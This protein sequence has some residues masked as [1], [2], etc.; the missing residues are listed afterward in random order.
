[1]IK[2]GSHAFRREF[3]L[4]GIVRLGGEKSRGEWNQE[5]SYF[6]LTSSDPTIQ[7]AEK[8]VDHYGDK[9]TALDVMFPSDDPTEVFDDAYELW[10]G[11]KKENVKG[12]LLCR[13]D[14]EYAERIIDEE[15]PR[16]RETVV[17]P[18]PDHCAF[19]QEHTSEKV[20]REGG[21]ACG[22]CGRLRFIPYRVSVLEVYEARTGSI[23]AFQGIRNKLLDIQ[24]SPIFQGRISGVPFI[25][26]RVPK[27][28]RFGKTNYPCRIE[29]PTLEEWKSAARF[30][31]DVRQAIMGPLPSGLPK[32]LP[33]PP[34]GAAMPDELVPR[35]NRLQSPATPPPAVTPE[36]IPPTEPEPEAPPREEETPSAE[37][38]KPPATMPPKNEPPQSCAD[39]QSALGP[40]AKRFKVGESGSGDDLVVCLKCH[41]K[42]E[43]N[44]PPAKEPEPAK[45]GGDSTL[46]DDFFGDW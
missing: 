18:T 29:V 36:V 17:C 4:G 23:N 34:S 20:K 7:A 22:A 45:A 15:K 33:Q 6:R 16:E 3:D 2:Q 44:T 41:R 31:C 8:L 14:G 5:L 32:A 30:L 27:R 40:R 19:A 37:T 9:P 38:R 28:N 10:R 1:V 25:L 26:R 42:R 24:Q 13:G 39:C 46:E 43:K 12:T 11:S 35:S 21:S